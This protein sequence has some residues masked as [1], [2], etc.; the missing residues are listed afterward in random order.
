MALVRD[1]SGNGVGVTVEPKYNDI[2][3][4]TGDKVVSGKSRYLRVNGAGNITMRVPGASSDI[5]IA[6]KDGE[7]LPIEPGTII[8]QTGTAVTSLASVAGL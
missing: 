2:A 7:Y 6:A 5:V 8:R 4:S 1:L 3:F